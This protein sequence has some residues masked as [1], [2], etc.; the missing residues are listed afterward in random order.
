[1]RGLLE[2][3]GN[4]IEALEVSG[5]RSGKLFELKFGNTYTYS[6]HARRRQE[7]SGGLTEY[8]RTGVLGAIEVFSIVSVERGGDG[9]LK[10]SATKDVGA[11]RRFA[12]AG[13]GEVENR[14][15]NIERCGT[16]PR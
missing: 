16:R 5:A 8:G 2:F 9:G 7:G 11:S 6:I 1:M 10:A 14:T 12:C 15:L 13:I 3:R 4:A